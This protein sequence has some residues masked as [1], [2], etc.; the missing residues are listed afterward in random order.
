V[1]DPFVRLYVHLVWATWERA[2]SL[3]PEREGAVYGCIRAECERLRCAVLGIGGTENHIHVLVRLSP[4][5]SVSQLVKQLKGVSSHLMNHEYP[6]GSPFKW[7]G[8]Y[9]VFSVQQST[10]RQ[11][12]EYIV[13]QKEHHRTNELLPALERDTADK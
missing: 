10:I 13:N 11:V 4:A 2:P 12:Q 9:G 3:T 5:V 8:G 7:Q 6:G 1:S